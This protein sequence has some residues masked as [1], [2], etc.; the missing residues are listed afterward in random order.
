MPRMRR[1]RL[2]RR[3]SRPRV[4]RCRLR[5]FRPPL[6]AGWCDRPGVVDPDPTDLRRPGPDPTDPGRP[7]PGTPGGAVGSRPDCARPAGPAP[8]PPVAPVAATRASGPLRVPVDLGQPGRTTGG[9]G[10]AAAHR[11][12]RR[13][14]PPAPG[15]RPG[16]AARSP[17]ADRPAPQFAR[18]RP[19]RP[20]GARPPGA[21]VQTGPTQAG[22]GGV[23][24]PIGATSSAGCG[25]L[26]RGS[27]PPRYL[28]RRLP[29]AGSPVRG[30][31]A[32]VPGRRPH[33]PPSVA[34]DQ[35]PDGPRPRHRRRSRGR[36]RDPRPRSD[37]GRHRRPAPATD[38][39]WPRRPR[40]GRGV[41]R[42]RRRDR[43]R[44]AGD[45]RR[46]V[47]GG[48]AWPR[49]SAGLGSAAAAA[50][51]PRRPRPG[52]TAATPSPATS[53]AAWSASP[54]AGPRPRVPRPQPG[55][56]GL[57]HRHRRRARRRGG[58]RRP[59]RPPA[60]CSPVRR[61]ADVVRAVVTGLLAPTGPSTMAAV[62]AGDLLPAVP[63]FPGPGPDRPLLP[64]STS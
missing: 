17:D 40:R 44:V 36:R 1:R 2:R 22:A 37:R 41:R 51:G 27:G 15:R 25:A 8:P 32:T 62:V 60:W 18:H 26:R 57:G 11:P 16:A 55:R 21:P 31:R 45:G 23:R 56:R 59:V 29:P 4:P 47:A 9:R 64:P 58:R 52:S 28:P 10:P 61:G 43:V 35:R 7:G 14:R 6:G 5:P 30:C 3:L 63:P 20:L 34:A 53:P 48:R 42:H 46:A 49:R 38:V 39:R 54:G 33:A 13:P 12:P 50:A 19:P 24:V